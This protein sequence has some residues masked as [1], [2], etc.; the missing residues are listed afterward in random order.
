MKNRTYFLQAA[1]SAALLV[2]VG[3][4]DSNTETATDTNPLPVVTESNV[5]AIPAAIAEKLREIGATNNT[6]GTA[7]LYTPDFTG[8]WLAPFVVA[9][10]QAY[11][12]APRN[13]LDVMAPR[14][15]AASV[16]VLIFVH[17]GGFGGGNKSSATSPFYDN[18]PYWAASHGLVGVNINYRYAPDSQWPAGIEDLNQVV[19]WVQDNIAQYGGDPKRI[20]FWGKS[21]GASHVAD[22]L[23]NLV[24]QGLPAPITG[25]IFTSGSYA[26][27]NE[28]LWANYYG[29]DVSVY[30][31]RN[32]LP[33]LVK[34]EVPMLATYGE[35][36][37][38]Q[39][40]EQFQMFREAASEA[41]KSLDTLYLRNHSHMSETYAV[42]TDDDSLTAPVLDF[43]TR[44]S[45]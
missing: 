1:F 37:G 35:Y 9:R 3:C 40:K 26:L 24:K 15:L 18:I 41:G 27:G 42:G 6:P 28:P 11:G 13:A 22:Y 12:P 38:D 21:T 23:A 31:Q 2:T 16:P 30:P 45:N 20:F 33:L 34:S 29:D 25:A 44:Y 7:A 32:A 19:A 10:D 39:Y 43:I 36:D 14:D 8:D 5:A 4:S 17:G